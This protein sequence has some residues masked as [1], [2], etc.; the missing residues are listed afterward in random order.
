MG[1]DPR[2]TC[3]TN[4]GKKTE[5]PS[6]L[7]RQTVNH[8]AMSSSNQDQNGIKSRSPESISVITE[9]FLIKEAA[10]GRNHVN[11]WSVERASVRKVT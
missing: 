6:F 9:H 4:L 8:G 3:R 7:R 1:I 10:K 2:M 11:A 5:N